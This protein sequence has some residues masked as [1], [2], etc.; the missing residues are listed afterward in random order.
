MWPA[1]AATLQKFLGTFYDTMCS[2]AFQRFLAQRRGFYIFTTWIPRHTF[3][4]GGQQSA[5]TIATVIQ[6]FSPPRF[7][8]LLTFPLLKDP[9]QH[10]FILWVLTALQKLLLLILL[11][12]HYS[13]AESGVTR[14]TTQSD[15]TTMMTAVTMAMTIS[16]SILMTI[17]Y[18]HPCF[19]RPYFAQIS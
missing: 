1:T 9:L 18:L 10:S 19:S 15:E 13:S 17:Q 16:T 8:I 5:S 3:W 7:T 12:Y 2:S 11:V 14:L 4:S 6:L